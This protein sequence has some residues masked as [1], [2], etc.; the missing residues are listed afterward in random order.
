M[1]KSYMLPGGV[2]ALRLTFRKEDV[3]RVDGNRFDGMIARVIEDTLAND[4]NH[5]A[6]L[7]DLSI[8]FSA[9]A[10]HKPSQ[11]WHSRFAMPGGGALDGLIWRLEN[12]PE[13]DVLLPPF[14]TLASHSFAPA[15]HTLWLELKGN[16]VG[17]AGAVALKELRNSRVLKKLYLGLKNNRIDSYGVRH[18]SKL[19]EAPALEWLHLDLEDNNV[20]DD[21]AFDLC[22]FGTGTPN[23][24]LG[25]WNL[26][27][28]LHTLILGLKN[29]GILNLGARALGRMARDSL[30]LRHLR[31]NLDDNFITRDVAEIL[32]PLVPDEDSRLITRDFHVNNTEPP[33]FF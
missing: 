29:N 21:G 2:R 9:L 27:T 16:E 26:P 13:N 28:V 3:D 5:L 10:L 25:T 23:L 17:E 15:L 8:D 19:R 6:S 22:S 4:V 32:L 31:V 33:L 24:E 30:I 11:P 1:T 20:G 12:A 18:L 14:R 7:E